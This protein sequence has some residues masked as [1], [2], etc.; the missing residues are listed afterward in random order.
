MTSQTVQIYSTASVRI[1]HADGSLPRNGNVLDNGQWGDSFSWEVP[2]N[3]KVTIPA[4]TQPVTITFDDSNGVLTDDPYSGSGVVDQRL[5]QPVTID[6]VTYSPSASTLRWQYPPPVD[7]AL[8][9]KVTLYDSAGHAYTMVAISITQG[10]TT[11]VVG[12]AFQG[13]APPPGTTL[14]YVQHVSTYDGNGAAGIPSL[15]LICFLR[16]TAIATPQ[17]RRPIEGLRP[18][19]PVLTLD[20]G[21]Q[22]IRWIGCSR[23]AGTGAMAPLRIRAGALGNDRDLRVSPNHRMLLTG[24]RAEL[25]FGEAEVLTAAKF[26]IDDLRIRPEP[27][28]VAEYW[29]MLFDRHEIVFAEGA[30]AESLHTGPMALDALGRA[31]RAEILGLFPDLRHPGPG[32][33]LSRYELTRHEARSLRA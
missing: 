32:R 3:V 16:G 8:E 14:T 13:E 27:R 2:D 11:K 26:L 21:A 20:H 25:L 15:T 19:D 12:I 31:A 4:D 1:T 28:P 22:P 18:G 9:Y 33:A 23:T 10:Y 6:G 24:P 17:G 5:T 30:P 29:H 7:V